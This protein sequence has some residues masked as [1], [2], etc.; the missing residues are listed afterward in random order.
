MMAPA[1]ESTVPG[2]A[3]VAKDAQ[4]VIIPSVEP[5]ELILQKLEETAV[6]L[7]LIISPVNI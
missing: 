2:T 1:A 6:S 7:A 5:S 3:V 4:E